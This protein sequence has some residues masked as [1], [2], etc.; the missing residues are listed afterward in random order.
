VGRGLRSGGRPY[1]TQGENLT[2]MPADFLIGPEGRI[3]AAKYGRHP[4]DPWS[5]E[6]LLRLAAAE[7]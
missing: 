4:G 6:E 1:P 5:V 7:R 3:R 2:G